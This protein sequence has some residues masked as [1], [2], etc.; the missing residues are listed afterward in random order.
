MEQK[1]GAQIGK[2]AFIQSL[3]ILLALLVAAGALPL[4][5]PAGR[6]TRTVV[7]ERQAIDPASFEFVER[8]PYPI[9][10]W[11]TAPVEVL[12]G[13]DGLTIIVII[14][15]ILM[16]GSAFAVLDRSG[17]LREESPRLSGAI[18]WFLAFF[19][20]IIAVLVSGP[21]VPAISDFALPI[22]GPLFLI[23]GIG[24]GLISGAGGKTVLKAVGEGTAGIAP[25]IPLILMAASVKHIV[26]Q[27][28][29]MDTILH[30]TSLALP[31][32]APS[33]PR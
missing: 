5:V 24:A 11:L 17:I 2:K 29:I 31:K 7:E 19:L 26:A 10:R 15:F 8:P 20:L 14:V 1:A 16:V 28:G 32:A 22:V 3:F 21:F 18:V 6:Y 27:G 13:P 12:G 23:G 33:W 4:V 25:G 9:W 30:S